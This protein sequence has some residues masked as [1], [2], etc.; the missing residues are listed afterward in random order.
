MQYLFDQ[1]SGYLGVLLK[2]MICNYCS[3]DSSSYL[4]TAV[5]PFSPL[6]PES[7]NHFSLPRQPHQRASCLFVHLY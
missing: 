7:T 6:L 5:Y 1:S 3:L 2:F 4:A